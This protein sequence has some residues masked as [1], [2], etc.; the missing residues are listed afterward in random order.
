MEKQIIL[1]LQPM[2]TVSTIIYDRFSIGVRRFIGFL[3]CFLLIISKS[4]ASKHNEMLRTAQSI[5]PD[6]LIDKITA[7]N[8]HEIGYQAVSVVQ[9]LESLLNSITFNDNTETELS[10]YITNSFTPGQ[11]ARVFYTNYTIVEDDVNPKFDL[12]KTRDVDAEKYLKDL[13]LSYEKTPDFSIKFSNF[14]VS[15]IK[16][17]DY[18]YI[19]VKFDET[20]DSK[21][22]VDGTTYP[23]R[24][25]VAEIRAERNGKKKWN[26]YI[27]GIRYYDPADDPITSKANTVPVMVNSD[28]VATPGVVKH[29]DVLHAMASM[30]LDKMEETKKEQQQFLSFVADGD[31][32]FIEGKYRAA[33]SLYIKAEALRPLS[34]IVN[35]KINNVKKVILIKKRKSG[36]NTRLAN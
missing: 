28:S 25:R 6:T 26:A 36:K 5:R 22:K 7:S 27:V 20:F 8:A 29:E 14:M 12:G 10:A 3:I 17:K 31:A 16:R 33:L 35:R 11:R 34:P 21:Y 18:I 32:S 1:Y 13:D 23:V 9:I 19:N 2:S 15:D 30:V 4:F 24:H